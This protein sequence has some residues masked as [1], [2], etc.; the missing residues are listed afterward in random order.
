MSKSTLMRQLCFPI[1]AVLCIVLSGCG[2]TEPLKIG[3][4]GELSGRRSEIGVSVR[5]AVQFKVDQVNAAGGVKGRQIEL[6]VHDN[7]GNREQ[8]ETII[9]SMIDQGIEFIVGPLLSQMAEPAV[10]AIEGKNVLLVSPTMSTDY[11]TGKD[12]NILRTSATT[13]MQGNI[14]AQHSLKS[15]IKS[16]SVIYDLSNQK[17]TELLYKAYAKKAA[18]SGISIPQVLTIDKTNHPK[19]LP[20]AKQIAEAGTD[21]VLMCLSA[22]DAA[23]L[24]Q[25][26]RKIGSTAKFYGVSWSQTDD[27]LQHGGRAIEGMVLISTRQYG[28][29]NAALEKFKDDYI[30]RYNENPS[31]VSAKGYDSMGLLIYG[32]ENAAEMSPPAVKSTIISSEGFQ[33]AEKWVKVDQFGDVLSGYHLVV[34]RDGKYTNEQ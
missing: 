25:Q 20:L 31:F 11:L 23:N 17:Y 21:G 13:T 26:L 22:V 16:V 5:N 15:N 28:V 30:A 7:A 33:G 19:M 24:A 9:T 8:C 29:K 1:I 2:D 34:V 3:F 6:I 12:D 10:K 4:V 32:L 27:L 18:D 14:L